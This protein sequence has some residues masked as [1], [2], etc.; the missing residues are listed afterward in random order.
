MVRPGPNAG[1]GNLR[2]HE[3]HFA[4]A[5][6]A[7]G[8]PFARIIEDPQHLYDEQR[9]VLLGSSAKNRLLVVVLLN[10]SPTTFA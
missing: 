1:A 8:D 9:F 6:T 10:L 2:K 5:S 4:E 3:V 7:F